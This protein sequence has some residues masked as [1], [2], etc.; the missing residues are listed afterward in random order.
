MDIMIK[1]N[2]STCC[3]KLS[4]MSKVTYICGR[5]DCHVIDFLG[6]SQV[7]QQRLRSAKKAII[8]AFLTVRYALYAT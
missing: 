6:T 7:A 1:F 3:P 5:I 4:A 8:C 2:K